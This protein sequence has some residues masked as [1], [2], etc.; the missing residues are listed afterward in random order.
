[1]ILTD[2]EK[3][4]LTPTYHVFRMYLPFQDSTFVPVT[5]DAGTWTQGELTLPR[6]D[7]IAARDTAGNLVL[8]LTNVDPVRPAQIDVALGDDAITSVT[9][10][11]LTGPQ[12]DSINTFEAPGTVVPRPVSATIEGGRLQVT[13]EPKSVSV[14]LLQP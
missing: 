5:L 4:L 13:L 3:M 11:T 1:M 8:A 10:E 12:V 2:K 6:V 14:F 9:G 7:V